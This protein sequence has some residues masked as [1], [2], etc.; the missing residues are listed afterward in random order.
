MKHAPEL[1]LIAVAVLLLLL[2]QRRRRARGGRPR[3]RLRVPPV[4]SAVGLVAAREIGERL[5]GR[6]FRVGTLFILLVVG[7]A[8]VIPTLHSGRESAQRVGVVG[9]LS[10]PLRAS[11]LASAAAVGTP[12]VFIPQAD[13]AVALADL[14][15]GQLDLV[16][17]DGRQLFVDKPAAASETTATARFALT[18]AKELGV[19]EAVQAAHL[20]GAQQA[21]LAHAQALSIGHLQPGGGAAHSTSLVGL[22]LIF[23]MLTQYNAWTMMGVMEE[24]AS[25]VIEVLLAAVRPIQLLTG[26]VLGIGLVALAQASLIVTFAI[27]LA[28]GVGSDLL[29]GSAPIAVASTLVWLLLGYA[30][31]SWVYAAAG[32]LAERQEQVQSLALP[33]SLP[34]IFGYVVA[35]TSAGAGSPSLLVKILAYIPLTA[36]FEMPLLVGLD[37]VS[38]WQFLASVVISL[39]ATVGMARLAA[40]IYRRAIL[41]TG[42]RVKVRDLLGRAA[43]DRAGAAA[44]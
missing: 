23:L 19:L 11:V 28:K 7:A 15:A 1:I 22:V 35:L 33:L 30:F 25:R 27:V 9:P 44:S 13:R 17:V 18:L 10:A 24:K 8:I 6:L 21:Q 4:R 2:R 41:R 42:G 36:P 16:V 31:Y 3:A 37:A 34:I 5:R 12:V 43:P 39:L 40:G 14:H 38:W 32:S 29:V 20:S 26:K